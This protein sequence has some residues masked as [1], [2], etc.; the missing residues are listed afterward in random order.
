LRGAEASVLLDVDGIDVGLIGLTPAD[1]RDIYAS[2]DLDVPEGLPLV[3]ENAAALRRRGADVV[4]LLS[5]LGIERDRELAAELDNEISLVIG[6]HSHTLLP[7]GERVGNVTIV[8]AGSFGEYLGRVELDLEDGV[9][10]AHV[11]VDPVPC[12]T[13]PHPAVLTEIA[14]PSAGSTAISTSPTTASARASRSWRTSSESAWTRRSAS[15]FPRRRSCRR[16]LPES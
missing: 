11:A 13:E 9:R 1:W 12:D 7:R 3:R 6:A 8:Q 14:S 5:H 15:W 16:C 10:I 4:I 2:M